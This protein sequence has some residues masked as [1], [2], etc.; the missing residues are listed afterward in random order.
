VDGIATPGFGAAAEPVP[1]EIEA[2]VVRDVHGDF[3]IERLRLDPPRPDEVVVRIVATGLCHTDVAVRDQAIP[4][5]L[6]IV[7]GHEGAGVVVAIGEA[8]RQVTVGDHVVITYLS[9]GECRPCRS[10]QPASCAL[11]GLHCFSGGRADGSHALHSHDGSALHDRFFGQSSFATHAIA[12]E[13]N[14]VKVRRDA[15]LELL[16]PLSCGVMTGAGTVWNELQVKPGDSFAVFGAGAVGLSA[17]MAAKLA[18]AGT[19]V[20]VDRVASRLELARELGA[21]HVATQGRPIP[22]RRSARSCRRGST[23]PSRPPGGSE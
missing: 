14:V 23:G 6:P 5:P 4:S 17:V 20:A 9:C 12:N 1:A 13:R 2:A 18:G 16:G 11:F 7:L 10:G 8:V 21:T 22:W 15:P 19:I 3:A